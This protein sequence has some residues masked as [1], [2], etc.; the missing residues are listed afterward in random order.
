MIVNYSRGERYLGG[1]VES[2][3]EREKWVKKKVEGWER[4]VIILAGIAK[5]FPQAAFAQEMNGRERGPRHPWGLVFSR[6]RSPL[7]FF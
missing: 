4:A 2:K 1:F 7:G 3:L 5:Q 6:S